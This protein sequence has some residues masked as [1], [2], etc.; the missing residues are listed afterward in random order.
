M[1]ICSAFEC[2]EQSPH[3]LDLT[4]QPPSPRPHRRPQYEWPKALLRPQNPQ[5]RRL[6]TPLQQRFE[7]P[8]LK[9]EGTL[10]M[11]ERRKESVTERWKDG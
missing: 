1:Q 2:D 3:Y 4:C 9:R 7:V 10:W 11:S 5:G 6:P 8:A